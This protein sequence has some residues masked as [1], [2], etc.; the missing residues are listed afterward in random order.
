MV[1]VLELAM[2]EEIARIGRDRAPNEACG[3]LLPEPHKNKSVFELPNRSK[4][5]ADSFEL[6]GSDILLQLETFCGPGGEEPEW[7]VEDLTIWHTHP[8][9][10][11]GPSATD[12]ASKPE[13]FTHLVVAIPENGP[14]V[15]TWF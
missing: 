12:M 8:G 15:A 1:M 7:N 14:P 10:G 5:P 4:M 2:V 13:T 6:W 3:I 11:V 9:G